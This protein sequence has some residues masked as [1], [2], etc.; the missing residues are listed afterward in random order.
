MPIVQ[1]LLPEA[2]F[3]P[4]PETEE[5]AASELAW[6]SLEG[7]L[8]DVDALAL[9]P[10]LGRDRSTAA[11]IR[12]LVAA[13]PVPLVLDA[14]GLNAFEGRTA[15]L[16]ARTAEAVLTP[17]AGEFARLTGVAADDVGEDRLRHARKAAAEFGWVV[18]LKGPRTVVAEPSGRA[19][20][21]AT[22]GP[23]LATGGTGDVLT[24]TI[25]GLLARGLLPADA[26]V[27]AAWLQGMAGDQ[28]GEELGDAATASDVLARLPR[29]FA[30]LAGAG[31]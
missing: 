1:G 24:G 11:L 14:D 7:R 13:S 28:A 10:G 25:A 31:S 2:V 21:N 3:I 16:T 4:L 23:A 27:C 20:V 5:G 9:G 19:R 22:G 15:D 18:L 12:R 6:P 30:A 17:H 8:G 29:A 26:A